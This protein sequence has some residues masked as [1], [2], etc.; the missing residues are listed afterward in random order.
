M[1]RNV[2]NRYLA[3]CFPFREKKYYFCNILLVSGVFVRPKRMR[4]PSGRLLNQYRLRKNGELEDRQGAPFVDPATTQEQFVRFRQGAARGVRGFGSYD[5]QGSEYALRSQSVDPHARRCDVLCGR[6]ERRR[7][8]YQQQAFLQHAREAGYRPPG[9]DSNR[10]GEYDHARFGYHYARNRAQSSAFPASDHHYERSQYRG[11]AVEI[12][13][14]QRHPVGR[15]PPR[16][17]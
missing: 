17:Q 12:Q 6:G 4:T 5:P 11:R 10:G 13:A 3:F 15:Q 9:C 16:R 2:S 14:I 7:C 8:V 1:F